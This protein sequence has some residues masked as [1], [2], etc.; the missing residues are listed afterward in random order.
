MMKKLN[1]IFIILASSILIVSCEKNDDLTDLSLLKN[2]WT[3]SYE[4]NTTEGIDIY[5]PSDYM[6]FPTSRFRQVF[7]FDKKNE[8]DYLVLAENDAHFFAKGSWEY[9]SQSNL[10][11]IF[12][13]NSIKIFEFEVLEIRDDLLKLKATS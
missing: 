3:A 13:S 8:C 5:R 12:D 1:L 9:D 2:S 4:E 6:N 10:M 7:I 11:K